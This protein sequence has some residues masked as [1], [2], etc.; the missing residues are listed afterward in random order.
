M[1]PLK[2]TMQAFGSY[3][4]KTSIDF[5]ETNQNLFLITGDTGAGKSTIFDAIVFAIYG[6]ASSSSNKKDGMELQSQFVSYET[7]PFVELTF[8]ELTGGEDAVY[9]VRRVPRHVRPLKK[10][11]GVKEEKETV[12][13]MM[14]DGLEYSQNQKETNKKLEEIVGLTKNQF[15]QVAMIAQGE[16]M[17]L[18]RADSNKKKEIFRKLFHTGFYQE[19]VDELKK[20]QKE[21]LSSMAQIRTA[22]QTEAA[23]I[24]IPSEYEGLE[25]L[26]DVRHKI[27]HSDKMNVADMEV[28]LEELKVFCEQLKTDRDE[29]KKSHDAS[30]KV[31]DKKRDAYTSAQGLMKSFEALHAAEQMLAECEQQAEEMQ[32][33]WKLAEE[34]TAAY[35][36]KIIYQ[37]YVDAANLVDDTEKKLS[38]QQ[39]L[40]PQ[41]MEIFENLSAE[42][43]KARVLKE[44]EQEAFT[45]V[46]ER[47][48]KS[49]EVFKKLQQTAQEW[50]QSQNALKKA[51]ESS[52]KAQEDFGE[53]EKQVIQ[54]KKQAETLE[55]AYVLFELWKKKWEESEGVKEELDFV[56]YVWQ[57]VERQSK[58]TD[59]AKNAYM[60]AREN[61]QAKNAEY[62]AKQN[63]FLDAQ[64]GF[65]AKEKLYPGKPCPVCG[66]LD[67]PKPCEL[68]DEHQILTREMIDMLAEEAAAFQK[69]QTDKST[70]AGAAVK[71]LQEKQGNF[72][73][74]LKQLK[75]RLSKSLTVE[76][77]KD[78]LSEGL[79][80]S[81]EAAEQILSDWQ[82]RLKEE[83]RVCHGNAKTLRQIQISLKDADEHMKLLQEKKDKFMEEENSMK[84]KLAALKATY[85]ELEK[86]KEFAT[87]EE[88]AGIYNTAKASREKAE[89]AYQKLHDD[90]QK[91]KTSK[92]HAEALIAQYTKELPGL[93]NETVLRKKEYEEVREEKKLE[94][95]VWMKI[96]ETHQKTEVKKYQDILETYRSKKASAEGAKKAALQAIG[97]Q[98]MPDMELLEA[99]KKE[100]EEQLA[101]I[102]KKLERLRED[103]KVNQDAY[104][105]LEPKMEERGRITKEFTRI[106][107]LYNR[108]AGKVSGARMDIETFVQR[109]YLQR[110]LYS[111]NLRFQEMSAGQFELR[112]VDESQAG[113]GRNRGLDLMVY[114]TVTGKE[115]EVRT[116]SGG[117]SFMA[118]LSLALGMADQIQ[119]SSAAINL[120]MMFID[121]GFGSLDDHSRNQ[122]VKVLQQM[123]NGSKLI[124]IIS[125]VTELKQEIEDQLI[126]K[127]DE[128]GSHVKWQ[129]S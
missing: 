103:Y 112:M 117:E 99:E 39:E 69:V 7:A 30:S 37:R 124:G 85:E 86:Q 62:M 6:E 68:S 52:V 91:A 89:A 50:K 71:L 115:R 66:S 38:Q 24:V 4:K 126:V 21:K 102:Q 54:W 17:E 75:E 57:D 123:A 12:S 100:A 36:I 20:R 120:D 121:E 43:G 113:E 23:H 10:G 98:K 9:T 8:S 1:R 128:E 26:Q 22:C 111:A 70:E 67:H 13:L 110:I 40:L 82:E 116:L 64:A 104:L 127:K 18:L 28:L 27:L 15:M 45:K 79:E 87:E 58:L 31:R 16:F 76:Q 56:K 107:S 119:E 106:D 108:L 97:K 78:F 14:P 114:S 122:A 95:S 42:E 3:G 51:S 32:N 92:E 125:H 55:N 44:K 61:Y 118:A 49:L 72:A 65:L 109:Y 73:E 29:A 83:G 90:S 35:D 11:T 60:K 101:E 34:I 47:V 46:A 84:M 41:L 93:K 129:I 80:F 48:K 96:A 94:E 59:K 77:E 53:L 2:L 105:A 88:A 25:R 81:L 5:Q 33:L 19:I 74:R 63:A